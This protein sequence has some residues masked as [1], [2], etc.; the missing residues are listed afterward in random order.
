LPTYLFKNKNTNE[1]FE[2]FMTISER[3]SYLRENSHIEQLFNGG[4]SIGDP[5]RL[6]R[7]KVDPRFKD[8]LKKIKKNNS[9]G[10][11][12]STVNVDI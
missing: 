11:S 3:T 8:L 4:P 1:E 12:R 10:F 6:G 2:K 5:I 9:K 7:T